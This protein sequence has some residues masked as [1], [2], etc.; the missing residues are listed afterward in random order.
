VSGTP[1]GLIAGGGSLPLEAAVAAR[2]AGREVFIAALRGSADEGAFAGFA[3]ESFGLGQ[4]G[5]L[6]KAMRAR[7]IR[8]VALIGHVVRPGISDLKPDLGLLRHL[9]AL[10]AAFERGDDGLLRGILDI[11][12][13][14]GLSAR[15]VLD[16]APALTAVTPGPI[17]RH[18][19]DEAA[20]R[21]IALAQAALEALDALDVGQAAVA[22]G[23]RPVA[24]EGPEGTDEMLLR[25]AVMRERRRLRNGGG[26]LVKRPKRGQ[27]LRVDLP[28]IGPS[29]VTRA[30]EAGLQGIAVTAGVTLIAQKAET[31]RLADEAG[32]FIEALP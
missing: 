23:G 30:R 5:G 3:C 20:A 18:R 29:T 6:L 27:D 31:I 22:V 2:G 7:A 16:L 11:L 9:P 10:K 32:L 12:D 26:V 1:I 8:E 15:S 14:E 28:T 21:Q 13:Q 24:I 4:L 17:G 25:V 19:A